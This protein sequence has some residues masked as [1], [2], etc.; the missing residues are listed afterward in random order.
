MDT[1]S[2]IILFRETLE[3]ALV[4]GIIL[5]YLHKIKQTQHNKFVYG[6]I[7][8]GILA[9]LLVAF[10]FVTFFSGFT[11]RAEQLFE[12]ITMLVA[13]LLITWM[14]FWMLR[15][16]HK[17]KK[18][19]EQRVQ[20]AVDNNKKL[21]LFLLPM[22]AILRDGVESVIFLNAIRFT[23]SSGVILGG[24]LGIAAAIFLGY[25]IFVAAKRVNLKLFF[26]ITSIFLILLTAGLF[27]NATHEFQEA[28]VIPES[29]M[30]V[31]NTESIVS[32]TGT[33]GSILKSMFGYMSNP[34]L[35]EVLIYLSYIA[36]VM[37]LWRKTR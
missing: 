31:W 28:G 27:A 15:Q 25:L 37:V 34:N 13:G 18:E 10:A 20:L 6:G 11:G 16:S 26:S 35:L 4:I 21:E 12:G 23:S 7:A 19:T 36:F 14:V 30:K 9:C 8:T 1:A 3:A 24:V 5:S 33:Y 32:E 17:I 2:F 22:I 29:S